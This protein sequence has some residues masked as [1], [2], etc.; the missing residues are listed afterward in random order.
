MRAM[1]NV[2]LTKRPLGRSKHLA[3]QVQLFALSATESR[4]APIYKTEACFHGGGS[5]PDE[6]DCDGSSLTN[7]IHFLNFIQA[8][9]PIS[10][11]ILPLA[12]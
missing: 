12:K 1:W 5:L 3:P 9:E 4:W 10:L 11:D 6:A 8:E 7:T 2:T